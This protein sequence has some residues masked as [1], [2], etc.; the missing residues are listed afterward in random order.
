VELSEK[1]FFFLANFC[2]IFGHCVDANRGHFN[3]I[4]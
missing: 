3:N 1:H 4:S 2:H